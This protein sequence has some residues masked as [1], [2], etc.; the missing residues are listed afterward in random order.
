MSDET[1][2]GR[3]ELLDAV[4]VPKTQA[5]QTIADMRW[6]SDSTGVVYEAQVSQLQKLAAMAF[7]PAVAVISISQESRY[8]RVESSGNETEIT[9]RYPD[10]VKFVLGEGWT[11]QMCYNVKH[12][13]AKTGKQRRSPKPSGKKRSGHSRR[14]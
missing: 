4:L 8:V 7:E 3:S 14:K 10:M 9:Q 12:G 6:M 2:R 13:T 11:I 1:L 5:L